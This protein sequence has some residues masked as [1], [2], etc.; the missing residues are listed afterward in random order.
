MTTKLSDL[1]AALE[2]A[3]GP[4]R[5]LDA[6]ISTLLFGLRIWKPENC[7]HFVSEHS[8]PIP[9][10]PPA[11]TSSLDAITGALEQRWSGAVWYV[12]NDGTPSADIYPPEMSDLCQVTADAATPALALSLAAA[13]L[14]E[15][16]AGER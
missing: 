11:Y 3:T 15:R 10:D 14:A 8:A 6:E 7:N 13:R 12:D 1:A 16:E 4:S 2:A 5:E 9:C